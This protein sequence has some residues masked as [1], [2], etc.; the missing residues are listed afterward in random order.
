MIVA[1]SVLTITA[2]AIADAICASWDI[3]IPERRII[4]VTFGSLRRIGVCLKDRNAISSK[5]IV[6]EGTRM[7]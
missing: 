7:E 1:V 4:S 5:L 3:S 6:K 2:H